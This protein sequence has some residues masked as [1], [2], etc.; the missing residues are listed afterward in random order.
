MKN[1]ATK[2]GL[3]A[4]VVLLFIASTAF[5]SSDKKT[6]ENNINIEATEGKA[7]WFISYI[8]NNKMYISYVFNNDCNHCNNE[9]MA[10]YKKHLVMN[11]YVT[12]PNT[13]NMLTY[14]DVSREKLDKRRD[15]QIYNRKQQR[16]TVINVNF[17]Y[18]E[19]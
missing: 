4:I 15:E 19:D 3:L 5:V 18:T 7:Y 10:A 17:S 11:D 8:F 13:A 6:E 2:T 14:H 12:N 16:Y 1:I 9:I